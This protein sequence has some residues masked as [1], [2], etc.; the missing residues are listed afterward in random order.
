MSTV[1]VNV[2]KGERCVASGE[3][4]KAEPG[5]DKGEGRS[6]ARWDFKVVYLLDYDDAPV[7]DEMLPGASV[8]LDPEQDSQS[9]ARNRKVGLDVGIAMHGPGDEELLRGD[10]TVRRIIYRV[11]KG[12]KTLQVNYRA[13]LRADLQPV[14]RKVVKTELWGIDQPPP[15]EKRKRG[16]KGEDRNQV[17]LWD[18]SKDKPGPEIYDGGGGHD[19][20]AGFPWKL[21]Q[22]LPVSGGA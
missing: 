13:N 7:L 14:I 17:G 5:R 22:G 15:P 1:N 8:M 18:A 16:K 12:L 20:A 6:P 21:G 10:A 2:A 11:A 9:D 19:H 3:L 4:V